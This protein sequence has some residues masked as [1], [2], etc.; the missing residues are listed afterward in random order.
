MHELAAVASNWMARRLE[1]QRRLYGGEEADVCEASSSRERYVIHVSAPWRPADELAWAHAVSIRAAGEVPEAIAPIVVGAESSFVWNGRCVA[2]FPYVDG[3]PLDR[4]DSE[5]VKDAARLLARI[6]AALLD[7]QPH[8]EPVVLGPSIVEDPLADQELDAWW[9]ACLPDVRRG[10]CHGDYYRRNILVADREI[11]GVIDWNG[12]HV[13]PLVREIA[14]AA[15]ELGHDEGMRL[16]PER[17]RLFVSAYR[18]EAAHVPDWEYDLIEGAA[19]IGLRDNIRYALRRGV[20]IDDEY[21]RRQAGALL[22]LW[23]ELVF[24]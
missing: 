18:S 13:G 5:R 9:S 1:V 10:V 4:E 17:F 3:Q 21:Q 14:F 8:V 11:R 12:S 24:P 6:H 15:W 19:C 20:S 2:V 16:V 23:T 22:A 7:W